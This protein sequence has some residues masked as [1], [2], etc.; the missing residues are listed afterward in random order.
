MITYRHADVLIPGSKIEALHDH[1]VLFA[2]SFRAH[3]NAPRFDTHTLKQ[4]C[5][6]LA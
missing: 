6:A 1:I 2:T 4:I 3:D 5:V